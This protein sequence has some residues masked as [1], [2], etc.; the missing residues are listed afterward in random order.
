MKPLNDINIRD[1]FHQMLFLKK[2]SKSCVTTILQ[3]TI[4][5]LKTHLKKLSL[6]PALHLSHIITEH[7]R[8]NLGAIANTF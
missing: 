3:E 5:N 7:F 8:A 2:A 6:I 1:V 4:T